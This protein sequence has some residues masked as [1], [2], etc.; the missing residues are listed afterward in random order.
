MQSDPDSHQLWLPRSVPLLTAW[1]LDGCNRWQ[2]RHAHGGPSAP[3]RA[4]QDSSAADGPAATAAS[5]SPSSSATA[6]TAAAATAAPDSATATSP[7]EPVSY[8]ELAAAV[9]RATEEVLGP[10]SVADLIFGLQVR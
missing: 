5:S 8:G 7:A 1:Q 6:A 10:L 9:Y 3:T 2:Q 4:T